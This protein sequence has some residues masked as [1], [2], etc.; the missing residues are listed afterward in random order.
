MQL[1]RR[2]DM[3]TK[4]P[5]KPAVLI[6]SIATLAA[7][8][9]SMATAGPASAVIGSSG[10]DSGLGTHTC[11]SG[12]TWEPD[13]RAC[14]PDSPAGPPPGPP[15][16]ISIPPGTPAADRIAAFQF[17]NVSPVFPEVAK[18]SVI[19]DLIAIVRSPSTAVNQGSTGSCGPAAIEFEL[20][21]REPARFVDIVRSIYESGQFSSGGATYTAS[22]ELR[23]SPAH[24]D[25]TPTNWLFMATLRDS[26]NIAMRITFLTPADSLAYVSTPYEIVGWEMRI[27]GFR[28]VSA[29]PNGL[30]SSTDMANPVLNG[31]GVAIFLID[32]GL[33][34]SDHSVAYPNHYIDVVRW[35]GNSSAATFTAQT[36]G[37]QR[38]VSVPWGVFSGL[39]YYQLYAWN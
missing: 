18:Q 37:G 5:R 3:L 36:W 29:I 38:F 15:P 2:K 6:F 22:S 33:V 27:L 9:A 30:Q 35:S 13:A 1:A 8:I 34:G 19:A 7:A 24:F 14:L 32:A 4:E 39:T 10:S 31:G 26:G 12:S 21:R 20:A 25:I 23:A 17:D 28:N 16:P 11:P